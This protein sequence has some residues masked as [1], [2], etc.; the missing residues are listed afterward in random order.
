MS[1]SYLKAI[2]DLCIHYLFKRYTK[3]KY[4]IDYILA[5]VSNEVYLV[6]TIF[7]NFF[8]CLFRCLILSIMSCVCIIKT[9][10]NDILYGANNIFY[11]FWST[12]FFSLNRSVLNVY[13]LLI[14]LRY[15]DNLIDKSSIKSRFIILNVLTFSFKSDMC[16]TNRFIKTW[17]FKHINSFI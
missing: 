9:I 11:F 15:F 5:C 3:M 4:Y 10:R 7:V 12:Q 13:P 8:Y 6:S 2:D 1:Y 17:P 14:S 16:D